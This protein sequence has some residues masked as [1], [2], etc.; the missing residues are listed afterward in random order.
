MAQ[1][2]IG[3]TKEPFA[4]VSAGTGRAWRTAARAPDRVKSST[5]SSPGAMVAERRLDENS[6]P[7]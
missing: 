7:L 5:E 4:A 1:V 2:E 6:Q 3:G